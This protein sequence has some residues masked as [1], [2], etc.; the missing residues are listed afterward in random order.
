MN[1]IDKITYFQ[2]DHAHTLIVEIIQAG[3]GC[4]ELRIALESL[5]SALSALKVAPD[6]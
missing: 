3:D 4:P 5:Q 6:A 1:T 2:L